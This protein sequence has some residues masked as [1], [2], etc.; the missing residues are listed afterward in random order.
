MPPSGDTIRSKVTRRLR[1]IRAARSNRANAQ[2]TDIVTRGLL[3]LQIAITTTSDVVQLENRLDRILE[4]LR[5]EYARDS[6]AFSHAQISR[7]KSFSRIQ[8]ALMP[9]AEWLDQDGHRGPS[10]LEYRQAREAIAGFPA[11]ASLP[12]FQT[13]R[14][15]ALE[16]QSDERPAYPERPLRGPAGRRMSSFERPRCV[17]CGNRTSAGEKYC[18]GCISW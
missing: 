8:R 6:S 16:S 10:R 9:I 14:G 18:S 7:L 17:A 2:P 11:A 15:L 3:E 4:G 13:H 12:T 5:D 1:A